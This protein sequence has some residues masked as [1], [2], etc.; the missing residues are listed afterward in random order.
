ML[1]L[2]KQ[3]NGIKDYYNCTTF[4]I[5]EKVRNGLGN[6]VAIFS[7]SDEITYQE[8]LFKVNQFGN[9]LK[10]IGVEQENRILHVIYDSPEFI[11]SFFGATKIGA[12]PIPVNTAMK[13]KD[14]EYFL[15][16]SRSR[17]LVIQ[18]DVWE[19]IKENRD[20]FIF[21]KYII[22]ISETGTLYED[23]IDYDEFISQ[24]SSELEDAVT[25]SEDQAF[26]LYSSG[27][28]GNPKGVVHIHRSM[29]VAVKNYAENILK[30]NENDRT[31]SA[32]KLYFAYG[33]GNGMYFPLGT[34]ASTVLMKERPTPENIFKTI[35]K[36]K[37]TIFFCVPTLYGSLIQYVEKTGVIPDL[38]SVRICV[39][40]G[41]ALPSTFMK[42]W[43]ELF[44]LD[45]LDGIGSTEALHIFLSNQAHD[46]KAG[47]TGKVVPG[48]KAK[49]VNEES[50][51]VGVNEIGDLVIQ[52]DSVSIGYFCNLLENQRKFHGEWMYTGDK[53]YQD[54]EGYFW[55]CGRSDDMLKVGGIWV[56]PIE[57]ESTLI[58]HEY[59]LEVA[60][61][62][63]KNESNLVYPKA[64]I[65]LRDEIEPTEDL[66]TELKLFVK[67][68]LAPYKYPR[69]IEFI[70][71]LPK[72]ATGKVQRFRLKQV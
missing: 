8:L 4:F 28:T 2:A 48:Y 54:E 51:P 58:R 47:S 31:F 42:K 33:L 64:Y 56:S 17:V 52:G 61:V 40:A 43:K 24:A 66:K 13:P 23:T 71:E 22:V 12:I 29:E 10:S 20:R 72:T 45:I 62:G 19:T 49:I 65:V 30:V 7:D 67:Q 50:K 26:W 34:G 1:E 5:E 32:S 35:E 70:S 41:E 60:V 27:S 57:I 3:L 36:N 37:P 53:Y 46:I 15:N 38:S 21:L 14:Y 11:Y 69:E 68:N 18:E 63:S 9:A 25:T 59:V 39:S 55:Y 16:H 44:N 6:K